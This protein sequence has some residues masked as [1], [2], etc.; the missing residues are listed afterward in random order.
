MKV[1]RCLS[2]HH[3][4]EVPGSSLDGP[5]EAPEVSNLDAYAAGADDEGD[6]D[7]FDL[8]GG[9]ELGYRASIRVDYDQVHKV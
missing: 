8:T 3:P 5:L 7:R 4:S 2:E 9:L 6:W 1:R